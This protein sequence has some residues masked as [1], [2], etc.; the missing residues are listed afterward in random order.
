MKVLIIY[1]SQT[2]N[3]EKI[4]SAIYEELSLSNKVILC[5][6][7]EVDPDSIDTYDQVF[8]GSPIHAGTIAKEIQ[9]FLKKLPRL[10]GMRLA[11]FI[12]HAATAYPKQTLEQMTQPFVDI[13]RDKDM[14]YLGC[15]NCQGYLADF[16]HEAVQKMQNASNAEWQEKVKRMTGHPNAND[17][18]D[19][20]TFARTS[21][22]SK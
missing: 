16:M 20:K 15:F 21:L 5:K 8:I 18:A 6:L 17:E 13:C 4:A 14:E 12:T 2:G 22:K 3:T 1:L 9:D 11:G 19:A 10:P 7:D